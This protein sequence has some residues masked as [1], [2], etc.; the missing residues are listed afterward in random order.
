MKNLT[1]FTGEEF[2]KE[3][4]GYSLRKPYIDKYSIQDVRAELL[5]RLARVSEL[6]KEVEAK[7]AEIDLMRIK[8]IEL[9]LEVERLKCLHNLDHSLLGGLYEN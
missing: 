8:H 4:I 6:E 9:Q 1:D 3:F 2:E 7:D 5:S